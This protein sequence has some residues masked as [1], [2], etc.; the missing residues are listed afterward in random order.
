VSGVT[1]KEPTPRSPRRVVTRS[2]CQ[3]VADV[4]KCA[5][6]ASNTV[7]SD[8]FRCM[9]AGCV[10]LH[11]CSQSQRRQ[12]VNISPSRL[13]GH[14]VFFPMKGTNLFVV[15]EFALTIHMIPLLNDFT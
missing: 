2:N 9:I 4:R 8:T 13:T 6:D 10:R 7:T 12:S 5:I 1:D 11:L 15:E 14:T 3:S